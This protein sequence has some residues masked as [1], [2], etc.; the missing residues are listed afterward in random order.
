MSRKAVVMTPS[1]STRTSKSSQRGAKLVE[2]ALVLILIALIVWG[3][4]Y[5]TRHYGQKTP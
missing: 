4:I 1:C 3:T 5:F 2:Y